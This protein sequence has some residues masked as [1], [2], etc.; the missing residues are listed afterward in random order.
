MALVGLAVFF[1]SCDNKSWPEYTVNFNANGG[2]GWVSSQRVDVRRADSIT[3]PSGT[4]FSRSGFG[5]AGWS[6]SP[7]GTGANFSAGSQFTPGQHARNGSV[8]LYARWLTNVVITFHANGG[9]GTVPTQQTVMTGSSTQLPGVSGLSRAGFVF[10]GWNTSADGTGR[11]YHAGAWFTT[12]ATVTLFANWQ[13]PSQDIEIPGATLADQFDWLRTHAQNNGSYVIELNSDATIS[14]TD[15]AL[16]M[17]RTN[18]TIT[19]RGSGVM[20]T[21]GLSTNGS[22]F[23]VGFGV[24]LVLD[25]NIT[26]QGRADNSNHLVRVNSGGTLVMNAG[27]R[28]T[29]NTNTNAWSSADFGGGVR[30][31]SGGT[32]AM[33]GGEISGNTASNPNSGGGVN[34]NGGVFNMYGG[35]ITGN[36]VSNLGSGGGVY[37]GS[38]TFNMDDGEITGNT[39]AHN[40]GSSGGGVRISGGTFD[41]RGG[42]ISGNT[43]FTSGGGVLITGGT[44]NMH[45]GEI[46]SNRITSNANGSGGGVHVSSGTFNMRGGEISGNA[47]ATPTWDSGGGVRVGVGTFRI[48]DG[49]IRG[50][51]AATGLRNTATGN[52]NGAALFVSGSGTAQRGTFN[53]AGIFSSLSTLGT[54]NGTMHLSDGV[55]QFAVAEG[56]LAERLAWLWEFAQSGG[57]YVIELND[58]ETI[59]PTDAALPTGRTNLTIALRGNGAVRTIGLSSNGTLFT[60][61]SGV[62]LVLDN[63]ITLQGRTG[64][65]NHLVRVNSDSTL[66]MNAGSRVMGN[67][68]TSSSSANLGGGVR[69]N[70]GGTFIMRGGEIAGNSVGSVSNT[71]GGV[72]VASGGTFRISDGTIHGNDAEVGL[73]NTATDSGSGAALFIASGGTAQRG[74]FDNGTFTSLDLGL[75]TTNSTIRLVNGIGQPTGVTIDPAA[76]Y[77]VRGGTHDFNATVAGLFAPQDVTWSIV[78]TNVHA[79]TTISIAGAL[80]IAAGENRSTFTL[81]ATSTF[82]GGDTDYV[83]GTAVVTVLGEGQ[84]GA[85]IVPGATLAAQLVWL[86]ENASSDNSYLIELSGNATITPEQT[87]EGTVPTLPTDR[88]NLTITL[89]G[90]GAVRTV[91]LSADGVLFTVGSGVTLVLDNNITLQGRTGNNNHLVRVNSGG[92]LVMNAGSRVTGNT[93]TNTWS[94]ADFG[95]GVR[96]NSGGTFAMR[97]GEI[98][99]NSASGSST[100]GGVHVP[101]GGTFHIS[102]GVIRGNDAAEELRNTVT[103]SS[104]GA[105]LFNSGT[106][107]RGTFNAAGAFTQSGNLSTAN[108]TINVANGVLQIVGSLAEQLAQLRD[109]AQS[110][111]SYVIELSGNETIVPQTLPT[112]RTNLT[113]TLRGNGAARTIGLS[114]DGVLFTVGSGVTLVLDNNITLQGRT[115]NNNHLVRVNSGGTLVM[116]AGSRVTGNTNTNAWSSAD[117]GGGVR[118]NSGG[119][120]NMRGGEIA[121]NSIGSVSGTGGGVHVAS[122]GTFRISDGV[123]RGNDAA[124]GLR[125]TATASGSGASLFNSGTAQRGTFNAAGAFTQSGNLSTANATINV[126]NGVLQMVGSLAEQLAQLRDFAQNNGSYVIEL[127]G[128]ETITPTNAALPMNRTNLTITLRGNGAARTIGLSTDGA[129]FALGSGVTLVLDNNITLQGRTGN[130]NHLVRVNSGGTLVMNAGSRVTGNTNTSTLNS[131]DF[132]GGVRVNSGGTFNMRGGEI[133]SNSVGSVSNTGGGVHVAS[134]GTFRISDGVIHGND[135]AAELRNTATGSGSGAALFV[136]G[137]TAE[138][139][140]F[141]ADGNFITPPYGTLSTTDDT[142][143]MVNGN[144]VP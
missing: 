66:V 123:I 89:R 41:M 68:N 99:S 95:G 50:N 119:T 80:S 74:T 31:N 25:N 1:A 62:T 98:A 48:S 17:N 70:S 91:G 71:G 100:G 15:A 32:F 28:V 110:N 135:A 121:G 3:L 56:T 69:V 14:P 112:S 40:A 87:G 36:T 140:R 106:A 130:N 107:Q 124:V 5:F 20:R 133:A 116:N 4:G 94:S 47:V 10:A 39:T 33:R 96:V 54:A 67:T 7:D 86:R 78:E 129:L 37:I 19:L 79:Q 84:S 138:H 24:T 55:F 102:N 38:G 23:A 128:N 59:S 139:G 105:S 108:A 127:S 134:G 58:N 11:N 103:A 101:S 51:D 73:G 131:T 45:D 52:N 2:T 46:S 88:T 82:D 18:L 122:G 22:L 85:I 64:N 117:F 115:G 53:T 13:S 76:A 49:V 43:A 75:T 104:N 42:E 8:T 44:F 120:F 83:Y 114:T 137:G 136:S 63:N 12:T 144:A 61:G 132:G 109:F 97:G 93:N 141:D 35:E 77:V 60:I 92:T 65:N 143:L 118:V 30:V 125:N 34:L 57:S 81:R 26:L 21:I 6:L 142:I 16:P 111:R 9:G 72:H 126:A 27:S 113:I 90:N 29:G